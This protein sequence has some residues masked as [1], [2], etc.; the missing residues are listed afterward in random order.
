MDWGGDPEA[1]WIPDGDHSAWP[2]WR[3]LDPGDS[4]NNLYAAERNID[5]VPPNSLPRQHKI[6]V[7]SVSHK[8]SVTRSGSDLEDEDP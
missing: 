3:L 4:D 2:I 7:L 5:G 1:S 6:R 8:L